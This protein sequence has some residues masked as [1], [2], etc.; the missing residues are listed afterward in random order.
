MRQ[1]IWYQT[2]LNFGSSVQLLYQMDHPLHNATTIETTLFFFFFNGQH[3]QGSHPGLDKT[4]LKHVGSKL[5]K[6][7]CCRTEKKP[8]ICMK[9]SAK[10]PT[11]FIQSQRRTVFSGDLTGRDAK[12]IWRGS[13]GCCVI[14]ICCSSVTSETRATWEKV[15][16]GVFQVSFDLSTT[17]P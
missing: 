12:W 17:H 8:T 11:S 6:T 4:T 3:A 1:E 16:V 15:V 13:H 14:S 2:G 9:Q 7:T 10:R 5:F